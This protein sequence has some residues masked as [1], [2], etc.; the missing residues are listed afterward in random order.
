MKFCGKCGTQ[1]E[2]DAV[3]CGKCGTPC[4]NEQASK[5]N[6]VNN[7]Q[8]AN[9]PANKLNNM[10]K[11]TDMKKLIIGAALAVVA[12]F[13]AIFFFRSVIGSGA[14]TAKGAV[15]DYFKAQEKQSASKLISAT[16]SSRMYKVADVKKSELKEEYKENFE[17]EDK[18]SFKSI[19][20]KKSKN[21]SKLLV[22]S[23]NSY[24]ALSS[25]KNPKISKMREVT[26]SYKYREEGDDEWEKDEMTLT[27]YKSSG[28]WYVL[29]DELL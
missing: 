3:F 18:V 5:Q 12:I 8:T 27:L 25:G 21:I 6:T 19:K 28:N 22:K 15:K 29:P 1:L 16:M 10:V 14:I 2:D 11:G 13:V 17:D 23:T 7:S 24:Y 4:A 9:N 20:I 26:V